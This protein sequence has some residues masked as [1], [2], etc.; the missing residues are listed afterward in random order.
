[1]LRSLLLLLAYIIAFSGCATT[2]KT[3]DTKRFQLASFRSIL[4]VPVVNRSMDVTA[5]DYLLSTMTIPLAEKGYYVF[6]V[7]L[8]KRL[9]EDEGLSDA[10]LVHNAPS[11]KLGNLFGADAIMYVTIENWEAKYYVLGT[12]VT[13]QL[14]Y[15]LKDGRT[16]AT[17]WRHVQRVVYAPQN[18]STGNAIADLIVMAV[19]AAGTKLMPDYMPLA[20][21][22]N[23]ISFAYPGPGI[24]PGPYFTGK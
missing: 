11:A 12:T 14:S 18:S 5:S 22:A 15:I 3:V 19:N 9:L 4:V 2:T 16:G 20:R 24:P 1:M 10:Y 17:I 13:V 21:R 23:E 8:V 7:H 6:P